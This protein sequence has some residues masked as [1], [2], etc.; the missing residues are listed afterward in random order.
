MLVTVDFK[1][2]NNTK[3]TSH[4]YFLKGV[5]TTERDI[6]RKGTKLI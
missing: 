5:V 1:S 2:T 6:H 4:M 3:D